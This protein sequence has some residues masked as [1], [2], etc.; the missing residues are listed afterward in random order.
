MYEFITL[1]KIII[2]FINKTYIFK[3]M[4]IIFMNNLN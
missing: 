2:K 3:V 1:H 4:Y